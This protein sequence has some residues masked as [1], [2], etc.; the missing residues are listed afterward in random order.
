MS[1]GQGHKFRGQKS[2]FRFRAGDGCE[3]ARS[4]VEFPVHGR[5]HNSASAVSQTTSVEHNKLDIIAALGI[6][7]LQAST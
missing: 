5:F 4:C 6:A 7:P 2:G 3:S 1:L